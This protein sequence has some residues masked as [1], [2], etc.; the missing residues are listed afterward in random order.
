MARSRYSVKESLNRILRVMEGKAL[1][2][3]TPNVIPGEVLSEDQ[4]FSDIAEL[5]EGSLPGETLHIPA[6]GIP[7]AT[8]DE[9]NA[10]TS[11]TT[12]LSPYGH[13]IAHEYGGIYV[14]TGTASQS[15]V[16]DTWTKITGAFQ[17]FMLDSGAEILCDWND[18]RIVVNEVGTYL[19]MYD[20]TLYSDGI[21]RTTIDAEVFVSGTAA[22]QTKERG[23]LLV[24][25]SYVH[26]SGHGPISIPA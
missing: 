24:T 14:A 21:A 16:A 12:V 11:T 13:S 20:L 18:D 25:R 9:A 2:S 22:L 15:F 17:N 7:F 6:A 19:V 8:V 4:A 23:Q 10:G 1:T 5:W 3:D 26:I